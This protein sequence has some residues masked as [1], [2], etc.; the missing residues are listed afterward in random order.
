MPWRMQTPMSERRQ[1]V[2]EYLRRLT[3]MTALCAC[4]GISR[5]VGYKWLARY[6]AEG[7]RSL[8]D[9]SRRSHERDH[10]AIVI[11]VA[12]HVQH[13]RS[14]SRRNR[15]RNRAG[16]AAVPPF[17]KVRDALHQRLVCYT[18]FCHARTTPS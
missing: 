2:E 1:F 11:A 9:R 12:S 16:H 13:A 4:Y 3:S 8:A 10:G 14:R 17:G 6:L 5:R 15:V 7:D 18:G